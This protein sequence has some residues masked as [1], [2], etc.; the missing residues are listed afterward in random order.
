MNIGFT[1]GEGGGTPERGAIKRYKGNHGFITNVTFLVQHKAEVKSFCKLYNIGA[2]QH[3]C[4][5]ALLIM[6]GIIAPFEGWLREN[7]NLMTA[8][9][10]L[11]VGVSSCVLTL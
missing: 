9:A 1:A 10:S 7:K 4:D 5:S 6:S 8:K 2:T 11:T 3:C